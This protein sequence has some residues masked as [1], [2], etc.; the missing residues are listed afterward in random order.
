ML[1]IVFVLFFCGT[2]K[3]TSLLGHPHTLLMKMKAK[4]ERPIPVETVSTK[5]LLFLHEVH[6]PVSPPEILT[7][8]HTLILQVLV[9][10]STD[11]GGIERL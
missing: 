1:C 5:K 6:H 7:V 8:Q 9:S 2:R 4:V 11:W 3:Q 10:L